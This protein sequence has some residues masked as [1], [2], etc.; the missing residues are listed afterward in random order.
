[1]FKKFNLKEDVASNTIIKS[2]TQRAIRSK[3]TQQFPALNQPLI[4]EDPENKNETDP[5]SS[6]DHP[7]SNPADRITLLESLW[8]KKESLNLLK[9]REHVSI[10]VC[11]KT[12]L[13]FQHFDGPY[14]P[15]LK[16]LH[17]YPTLLPH[18]QVD[19]GAI[20]FVL[21]GAN[22]MC[23]G[24]T[25]PGARL[26]EELPAHT[27]VAV[28]AEGKSSACAIGFTQKSAADMRA[29]NKGIGVDNVHWLGDDLWLIE[30]I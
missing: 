26:P 8:P 29:V 28:H 16:L 23:P 19:R 24:L 5:S 13:F 20:K 18:V 30:E 1:M 6:L 14:F 10:L 25:S 7:A 27:P 3:L 4:E 11:K 17:Q 22:I 12:P 2:S 21:S 9:C 15:T